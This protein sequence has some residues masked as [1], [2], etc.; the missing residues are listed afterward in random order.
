MSEKDKTDR[1]GHDFSVQDLRVENLNTY[2][3]YFVC[4]KELVEKNIIE[5]H[6]EFAR[7]FA[8]FDGF[9]MS[10]KGNLL[11]GKVPGQEKIKEIV[12]SRAKKIKAEYHGEFAVI[13]K[14]RI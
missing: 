9:I 14:K 12:V 5:K 8:G 4:Y 11:F 10:V 13:C 6:D 2:N 1:Q 7:Y 3:D